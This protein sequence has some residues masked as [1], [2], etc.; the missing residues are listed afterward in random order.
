MICPKNSESLSSI[1]AAP[2]RLVAVG[3]RRV[4]SHGHRVAVN[5]QAG[6]LRRQFSRPRLSARRQYNR[7]QGHRVPQILHDVRSQP[8]ELPEGLL[9]RPLRG[10]WQ[11]R[12]LVRLLGLWRL[13]LGRWE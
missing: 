3:L 8:L 12:H 7:R 13:L 5:S 4:D 9:A 11:A 2:R 1:K 10:T 6:R